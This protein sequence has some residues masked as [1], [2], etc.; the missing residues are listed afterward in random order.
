MLVKI[1]FTFPVPTSFFWFSC[2]SKRLGVL[3]FKYLG[4]EPPDL[5]F[6]F[7]FCCLEAFLFCLFQL[8]LRSLTWP[9]EGASLRLPSRKGC[10]W[11][12]S[13]SSSAV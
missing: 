11:N 10:S 7:K 9:F 4:P 6:D 12:C 1:S 13:D 3:V 8:S 2:S 5:V